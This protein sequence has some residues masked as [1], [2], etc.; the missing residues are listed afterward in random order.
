MHRILDLLKF[1]KATKVISSLF[2]SFDFMINL[3]TTRDYEKNSIF[4][5]K[6]RELMTKICILKI[7]FITNLMRK[8]TTKSLTTKA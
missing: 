7:N 5:L 1:K 4:V 3:N 2:K 6:L 8:S